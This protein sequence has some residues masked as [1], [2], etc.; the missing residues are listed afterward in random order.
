[1]IKVEY[2]NGSNYELIEFDSPLDAIIDMSRRLTQAERLFA[3]N[4]KRKEQDGEYTTLFGNHKA[5]LFQMRV[6]EE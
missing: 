4:I 2:Y 5:V 1:M 6:V 3:Q